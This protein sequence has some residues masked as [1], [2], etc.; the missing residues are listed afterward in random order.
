MFSIILHSSEVRDKKKRPGI[1]LHWV[2][3]GGLYKDCAHFSWRNKNE[4]QRINAGH[5]L[6]QVNH[7]MVWLGAHSV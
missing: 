3:T 5:R 1:S 2:G 7:S 6:C 4:G